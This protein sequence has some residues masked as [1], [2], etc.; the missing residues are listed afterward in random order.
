[1]QAVVAPLQGGVAWRG[2]SGR[3]QT[4]D[5]RRQTAER[6]SRPSEGPGDVHKLLAHAVRKASQAARPSGPFRFGGRC[7]L[8]F[9][10]HS[11]YPRLGSALCSPRVCRF[12]SM[13]DEIS[14]SD[15]TSPHPRPSSDPRDSI[16]S[17]SPTKRSNGGSMSPKK[18]LCVGRL[19]GVCVSLCS[20][21]LAVHLNRSRGSP[22]VR[23][24]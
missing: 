16:L 19:G 5:G 10:A 4:A 7:P 21:L 15:G 22:P 23:P 17:L 9:S 13:P 20:A 8:E 12:D 14:G 11:T 3:Q 24:G 18:A 6:G 2:A 1:M